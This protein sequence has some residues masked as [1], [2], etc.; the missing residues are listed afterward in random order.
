MGVRNVQVVY[1]GKHKTVEQLGYVTSYRVG[2]KVNFKW[3]GRRIFGEVLL[4]VPK[5]VSAHSVA[6]KSGLQVNYGFLARTTPRG[7]TSY[8]VLVRGVEDKLYWPK[9]SELRKVR[10]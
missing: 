4:V 1:N 6:A 2:D 5:G 10:D 3:G 8:L 9:V 7:Q